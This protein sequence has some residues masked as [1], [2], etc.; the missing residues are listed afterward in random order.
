MDDLDRTRG[1]VGRETGGSADWASEERHW[2]ENFRSR[3]YASDDRDFNR[4]RAG[5]R[6][7]H[8]SANKFRGR[9]FDD[10]EDELRSGWESYEHRGDNRS[11]WEEIKG[12]VRDA[13]D[14]VTG[15]DNRTR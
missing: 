13:W 7:G 5:Y 11:T 15:N 6:Y 14:R 1:T 10:S 9:S 3:P 2:Q 4:Y 12:S 8:D